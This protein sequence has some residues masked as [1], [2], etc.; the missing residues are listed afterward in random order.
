MIPKE[1]IKKIKRLEIINLV[2]RKSLNLAS[3]PNS[4]IKYIIIGIFLLLMDYGVIRFYSLG[5]NPVI[6]LTIILNLIVIY[7]FVRK[8]WVGAVYFFQKIIHFIQ[9]TIVEF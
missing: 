8:P 5:S 2:L 3:T 4:Y 6:Y 9:Q 1:L 7:Y